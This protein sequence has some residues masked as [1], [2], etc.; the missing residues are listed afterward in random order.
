MLNY[1]DTVEILNRLWDSDDVDCR[2]AETY[3]FRD[4]IIDLLATCYSDRELLEWLN[5]YDFCPAGDFR[6]ADISYRTE[7]TA[8]E[9]EHIIDGNCLFYNDNY[10]CI[11]W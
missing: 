5:R 8:E 11:S 10:A 2:T 3:G 9:W 7:H 1:F 4:D 6:F